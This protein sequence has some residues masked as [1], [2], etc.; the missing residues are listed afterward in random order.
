MQPGGTRLDELGLLFA[1]CAAVGVAAITL[2]IRRLGATE[3]P[4][5]TVW[6]FTVGSMAVLAPS[7]MT[8]AAPGG[9]T[10]WALLLAIGLTGGTA[11]I[12]MTSS[13]RLAPVPVVAPFDYSQIVW[14]VALGWLLYDRLP[15]RA[16]WAGAAL[17]VAAG[18]YSLF[19]ERQ[20]AK[21]GRLSAR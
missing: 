2:A 20:L 13:L 16:T 19:R 5:T 6:W 18:L 1:V 12:A 10:A 7:L 11:Q 15:A 17:I 14:A 9:W 3:P 8:V 4:E 21:A